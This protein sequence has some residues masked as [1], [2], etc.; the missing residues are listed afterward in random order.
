MSEFVDATGTYYTPTKFLTYD[1][2]IMIPQHSEIKSRSDVDT[3]QKL[4]K[5]VLGRPFISANMDTITGVDMAIAM[6]RFGGLGILHRFWE[7]DLVYYDNIKTV[8]ESFYT[9]AVGFSVGLNGNQS[10]EWIRD[11]CDMILSLKKVPVVCL[12]VA[13]G[14]NSIAT[15]KVSEIR[16]ISDSIYL[17]AGNVATPQGALRYAHIGVDAVKIGIGCGAVCQTRVVAGHGVPQFSAVYNSRDYLDK[18]GYENVHIIADGGIRTSGDVAKAIAAG[19]SAVMIGSVFA[20]CSETPGEVDENGLKYYRGQSSK[21][22]MK[23]V[24]KESRS[25]EGIST[26]IPSKGSVGHIVDEFNG[27]LQ[28][29]MSYTGASTIEDFR[30]N[31]VFIEISNAGIVEGQ[32]HM[33]NRHG[34]EY[35]GE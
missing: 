6:A 7:N 26:K 11:V 10:I 30:K 22:F 4:N 9:C 19:A 18:M 33:L 12:D 17:I 3:S 16:S 14:D 5:I 28:S 15:E 1:D 21:T 29:A 13:H 35:H 34:V 27:G 8:A 20:G 23:E 32:T 31:A 25:S 24:G 2:V